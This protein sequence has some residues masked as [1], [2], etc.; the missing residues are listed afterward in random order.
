M[1]LRNRSGTKD[2]RVVADELADKLTGALVSLN[3]FKVKERL[4]LRAI[5]DEKDLGEAAVVKNDAV[6]KKLT[7]VKYVVV[8]AVT[9]TETKE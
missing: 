7:N 1:S 3:W 6:K 4:D 9:V 5:L 2:A 8:G